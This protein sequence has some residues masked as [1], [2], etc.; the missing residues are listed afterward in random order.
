MRHTPIKH[1]VHEHR[2]SGS[3]VRKYIRGEGGAKKI[4]RKS[5]LEPQDSPIKYI[6]TIEYDNKS[7]RGIT[8]NTSS[9]QQAL[10]RGL[11]EAPE[12]VPRMVKLKRIVKEGS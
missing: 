4:N 9:S 5:F 11:D 12:G 7:S 6:V 1:V 10:D 8:V 3:K 2:R